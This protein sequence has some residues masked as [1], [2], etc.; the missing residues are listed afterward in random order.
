MPTQTSFGKRALAAS[1][2]KDLPP[3]V[4]VLPGHHLLRSP[5]HGF[6]KFKRISLL[7]IQLFMQCTLS[8]V[9]LM[10]YIVHPK[11]ATGRP[12]LCRL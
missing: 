7:L 2:R 10:F 4:R 9:L 1:R 5:A 8:V 11:L 3:A 6:L 12:V